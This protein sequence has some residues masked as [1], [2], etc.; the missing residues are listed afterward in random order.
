LIIHHSLVVAAV[1]GGLAAPARAQPTPTPR[2]VSGTVRGDQCGVLTSPQLPGACPT[3]EGDGFT[4][5]AYLHEPAG[6]DCCGLASCQN[7]RLR[8]EVRFERPFTRAPRVD[9]S[10][11]H[12]CATVGAPTVAG[13]VVGCTDGDRAFVPS[14]DVT[15]HATDG[16]VPTSTPTP[17]LAACPGNCDAS[18][19]VT[20]DELVKGIG[21]ALGEL[22]LADCAAL[23]SDPD[24]RI[25]VHEVVRAVLAA[26]Y[27]CGVPSPT[28]TATP[29]VTAT[30]SPTDTPTATPTS[31]ATPTRTGT[32]TPT[33]TPTPASTPTRIVT[34][35]AT[36]LPPTLSNPRGAVTADP[37]RVRACAQVGLQNPYFVRVDFTGDVLGGTL[38]VF[39][40]RL[41]T[42]ITFDV[43]TPVGS[44][45][46][47]VTGN[48]IEFR[49]CIT[50]LADDRLQVD[51]QVVSP[52]GVT[53]NR[54]RTTFGILGTPRPTSLL[55]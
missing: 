4:V 19:E 27:G 6:A 8:Y 22:R 9:V 38:E 39:H 13:F 24:G 48:T 18:A 16:T 26:R 23:D 36:P 20:V 42:G 33:R 7:C 3:V 43:A 46:A 51:L 14:H 41:P 53:G 50:P 52:R 32:S 34:P 5:R 47:P 31:T 40:V 54:V 55:H 17:D 1:V 15:F 37:E 25:S 29:S 28:P 21:I 45:N 35:T 49:G 44:A 10:G 11:T 2:V 12:D 30:G